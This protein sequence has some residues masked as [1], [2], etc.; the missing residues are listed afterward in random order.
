MTNNFADFLACVFAG[1]D[2]PIAEALMWTSVSDAAAI[3]RRDRLAHDP[4]MKPAVW[5]RPAG[6]PLEERMASQ[7]TQSPG[8]PSALL[9][10]VDFRF[11]R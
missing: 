10:F 8:E 4:T 5:N 3:S 6:Q 1:L 11:S 2:Q 7:P 9:V